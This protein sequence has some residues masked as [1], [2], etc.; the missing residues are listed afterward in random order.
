MTKEFMQNL[1]HYTKQ[2]LLATFYGFRQAMFQLLICLAV[3]WIANL[4][5]YYSFDVDFCAECI[6]G[7]TMLYHWIAVFVPK[8]KQFIRF[9]I[10]YISW[11]GIMLL[12]VGLKRWMISYW[13]IGLSLPVVSLLFFTLENHLK[14][15]LAIHQKSFKWIKALGIAFGTFASV[16]FVSTLWSFTADMITRRCRPSTEHLFDETRELAIETGLD[17]PEYKVTEYT[18]NHICYLGHYSDEWEAEFLE[19][20]SEEFLNTIDSLSHTKGS[21][22]GILHEQIYHHS[23]EMVIQSNEYS[24]QTLEINLTPNSKKFYIYLCGCRNTEK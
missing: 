22:W 15:K 24:K 21:G 6:L 3:E 14:K 12:V 23:K 7:F 10:P 20:P 2:L 16:L 17:F 18:K 5:G 1:R 19:M 11:I 13:L 9:A 8:N 4:I